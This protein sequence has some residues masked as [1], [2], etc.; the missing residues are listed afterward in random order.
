MTPH[1]RKKLPLDFGTVDI[2]N[3]Y[4]IATFNEGLLF[5]HSHME[6]LYEIFHLYFPDRP[7]GYIS[8]RQ[9]EYAIDPTCYLKENDAPWLA[10]YA[11]LCYT[12]R[13]Y[14]SA[15]FER[16]FYKHRPYKPFYTLETC[17]EWIVRRVQNHYK[18][19]PPVG[20]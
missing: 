19:K 5:D 16:K 4:V 18:E 9:F 6:K 13:S 12:E 11:A 2:Y 10:A 1:L 20:R 14:K 17:L 3:D 7:F 8:N 15:L